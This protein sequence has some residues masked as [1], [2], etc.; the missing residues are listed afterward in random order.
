MGTTLTPVWERECGRKEE[1][2]KNMTHE[3]KVLRPGVLCSEDR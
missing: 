1:R 2:S 3:G